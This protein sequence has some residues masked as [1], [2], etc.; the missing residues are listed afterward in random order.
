MRPFDNF[1]D[2]FFIRYS[3]GKCYRQLIARH[4]IGGVPQKISSFLNLPI[5]KR[6]TVHCFRKTTATFLSNS[7][8]NMEMVKQ[9]GRYWSNMTAMGYT[10]NSMNHRKMIY[11]VIAQKSGLGLE[12]SHHILRNHYLLRRWLTTLEPTSKMNSQSM[13]RRSTTLDQTLTI[14]H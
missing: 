14:N 13:R 3:Q 6:Y 9:L 8:V 4:L 7:G 12:Q 2:R 11:N 5:L 10:K 1:F